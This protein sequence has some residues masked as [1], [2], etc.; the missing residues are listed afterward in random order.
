MGNSTRV[1]AWA[2][3]A[4]VLLAGCAQTG[5]L[6]VK[7]VGSYHIGGEQ[8]TLK[9]LPT[10][11]MVFSPGS[12]PVTLDPN[13]DFVAGQMYTRYTI[14]EKP[15]ASVPMLLWHGGGLSGTTYETKPDG[16]PG[17]EMDFLRDGWSVY[18]S[19]AVERGRASW[20]RYP[21]IFQG[22]P[23]F[24]TKKEAWELFRI[25]KTYASDPQVRQAIPGTL[26]PIADFDQFAK[27]SI[28]RWA[29]NDE[30]TQQAYDQYVQQACPCVIVVHS[31]GGNFALTSALKYPDKVKAVVLIEPSGSPDPDKTD[32]TPLRDVPMLWVWGDYIQDYPFWKRIKERQEGFR[33]TLNRAGGHGDLLDLPAQGIHGNS[34]ML[35]MDTNS[36]QISGLIQDWLKTQGLVR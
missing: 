36:R 25:G 34:H 16:K 20:A 35:M 21:E 29:T 22:E 1:L 7:E 26:F 24:R 11:K 33:A 31:Q 28:P 18:V 15:R 3:P 23:V 17:W 12:P 2:L 8:V 10:K 32:L 9:G 14:L 13:G 19:D 6:N 4:I 27:Q 5:G 30:R